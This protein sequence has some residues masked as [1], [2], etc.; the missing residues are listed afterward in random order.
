[1]PSHL[2]PAVWI[3]GLSLL[4]IA[5]CAANGPVMLLEGERKS[6]MEDEARA[7]RRGGRDVHPSLWYSAKELDWIARDYARRRGIDFR[8]SGVE[9]QIWVPRTRDCLARVEYSSGIGHPVLS[10]TIG[11]DGTVREH[12]RAIA[13]D[14]VEISSPSRPPDA[15]GAP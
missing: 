12:R 7:M 14:T 1:M 11:W 9:T 2:L 3:L 15:T 5:G 4:G 13:I 6:L 8:F 10:V